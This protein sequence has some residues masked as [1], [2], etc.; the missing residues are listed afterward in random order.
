MQ[1]NILFVMLV[2]V[3][4]IIFLYLF[5]LVKKGFKN[6]NNTEEAEIEE[7]ETK[8]PTLRKKK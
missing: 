7:K 8:K 4:T 6:N 1:G 5:H 3:F 2:I